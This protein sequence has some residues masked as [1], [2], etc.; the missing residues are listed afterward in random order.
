M[1][2]RMVCGVM[3]DRFASIR[4]LYYAGR[5]EVNVIVKD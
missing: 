3:G 2:A 1:P 4:G 5:F